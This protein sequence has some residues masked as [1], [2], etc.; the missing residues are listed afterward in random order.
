[1][2]LRYDF[3]SAIRGDRRGVIQ[4]EL[5]LAMILVAAVDDA[6]V[7]LLVSVLFVVVDHLGDH[8][9]LI[10]LQHPFTHLRH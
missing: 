2:G 8:K 10:L 1:M 4:W 6:S 5:T 7:V 3:L 9:P